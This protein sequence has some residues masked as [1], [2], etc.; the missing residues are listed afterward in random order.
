[1]HW[2]EYYWQHLMDNSDAKELK[3]RLSFYHPGMVLNWILESLNFEISNLE[4]NCNW[5]SMWIIYWLSTDSLP[6]VSDCT[7]LAG[8]NEWGFAVEPISPSSCSCS[9]PCCGRSACWACWARCHSEGWRS[10]K[11]VWG[12]VDWVWEKVT[13][14]LQAKLARNGILLDAKWSHRVCNAFLTGLHAHLDPQ[15]WFGLERCAFIRPMVGH[16][17]VVA[18]N[19]NL[20]IFVFLNYLINYISSCSSLEYSG[21]LLAL[22]TATATPSKV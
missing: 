2:C 17:F 12:S 22:E 6:T 15:S 7:S 21:K 3:S 20:W 16:H 10:Q 13:A 11:P 4:W 1:M 19:L 14:G 5:M 9:W 18:W 8:R